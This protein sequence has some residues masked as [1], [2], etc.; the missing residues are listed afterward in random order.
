[1]KKFSLKNF[2]N[3]LS[4]LSASRLAFLFKSDAKL[5]SSIFNGLHGAKT[6]PSNIAALKFHISKVP[7]QVTKNTWKNEPE[8]EKWYSCESPKSW[9]RQFFGSIPKTKIAN[10]YSILIFRGIQY[11]QFSYPA[12]NPQRPPKITS[13]TA[14]S[15]IVVVQLIFVLMKIFKQ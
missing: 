4:L 7:F 2:S 14:S 5:A 12:A 1:M 10:L 6:L 11:F 8:P 13:F 3:R 15:A 9:Q